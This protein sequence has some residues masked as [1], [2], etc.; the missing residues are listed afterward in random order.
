[1]RY[2]PKIKRPMGFLHWTC[3]VADSA[4]ESA[5]NCTISSLLTT[6]AFIFSSTCWSFSLLSLL[7]LLPILK[8]VFFL[9]LT[10]FSSCKWRITET[11]TIY[12]M[13]NHIR[14]TFDTIGPS[15]II[16]PTKT[17]NTKFISQHQVV[18]FFYEISTRKE[19]GQHLYAVGELCTV[20][21]LMCFLFIN[22]QTSQ[23]VRTI[24]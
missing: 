21:G 3:Q 20:W 8:F 18:H 23:L 11:N 10:P 24:N 6:K 1:M 12:H 15:A 19:R 17:I 7:L 5:S 4:A 14:Y 13:T 16:T 9:L 22:K 2:L